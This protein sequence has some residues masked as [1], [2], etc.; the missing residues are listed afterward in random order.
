MVLF[1]F[2]VYPV[3]NFG[4]FNNFE[5]GTD[6][7]QHMSTLY[8]V[9]PREKEVLLVLLNTFQLNGHISFTS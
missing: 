2:Q 9:L 4:K 3:C 7:H 8:T 1:L 5:H 6:K